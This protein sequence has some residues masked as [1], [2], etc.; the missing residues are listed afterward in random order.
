MAAREYEGPGGLRLTLDDP[1]SPEMARQVATGKLHPVTG[2][3]PDVEAGD[4]SLVV[5]HGSEANTA[6]RVGTHV[7]A[8]GEKP[9]DEDTPSAWAT[10]AVALGMEATQASTLS[11]TQLQEWV[12]VHEDA[13][14][15]GQEAPVPDVDPA[16]GQEPLE[17]DKPAKNAAVADW[18]AYAIT[19][20]MDPDEAK[21]AT[22]TE[23]QDYAQVV[24]DARAAG[25]PDEQAGE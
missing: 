10:Y 5:V 24:E 15:E 25:Q 4:K 14:G 16:S 22:K 19:L 11:L 9:G 3:L 18:R 23:C 13:L 8:P 6:D 12:D 7:R 21:T 1:L 20:G 17:A 2:S